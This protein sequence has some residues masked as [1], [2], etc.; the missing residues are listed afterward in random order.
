MKKLI[1]LTPLEPYFFGGETIF[2]GSEKNVYYT[3]SEMMMSQTTA[4]GVLRYLGIIDRSDD[5]KLSQESINQIGNQSFLLTSINEKYGMINGISEV[6]VMDKDN[7]KYLPMPLDSYRYLMKENYEYVYGEYTYD[8]KQSD[9]YGFINIKDCTKA[10]SYYD[11]FASEHRIGIRKQSNDFNKEFFKKEMA[12]MNEGY[13]FGF[14]CDVEDNFKFDKD[15]LVYLGTGKSLFRCEILDDIDV[16]CPAITNNMLEGTYYCASNLYLA[17]DGYSKLETCIDRNESL[18]I[19]KHQRTFETKY[20]N[21]KKA[22]IRGDNI[23]NLIGAGSILKVTNLTIFKE[24][25]DN[26]KNVKIAG[27]NQIIAKDGGRI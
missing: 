1:K 20:D 27:F 3:K 23:Y 13:S 17:D 6:F 16:D 2:N 12:K 22:Y 25:I 24:L 18:I 9:T 14:V 8:K 21:G 4:F 5:F 11:V 10:I 7:N 15:G 19:Y 26:N